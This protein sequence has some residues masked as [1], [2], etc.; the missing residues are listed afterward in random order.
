VKRD[1][2]YGI[3]LWQALSDA[4]EAGES[5][6]GGEGVA[7]ADR[8]GALDDLLCLGTGA[9]LKNTVQKHARAQQVNLP[10]IDPFF[11]AAGIV[12]GWA[13]NFCG[14]IKR[15]ARRRKWVGTTSRGSEEPPTLEKFYS[16]QSPAS[17]E[18]R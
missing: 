9:F 7:A 8:A 16:P 3:A 13:S 17:H 5:R 11:R 6:S 4:R 15:H 14:A 2:D 18:G 10:G 12:L 1:V